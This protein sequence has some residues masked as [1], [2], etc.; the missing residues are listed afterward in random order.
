MR[1]ILGFGE[2]LD[3]GTCLYRPVRLC[4]FW[5]FVVGSGVRTGGVI[6]SATDAGEA[7]ALEKPVKLW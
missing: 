6:S 7:L 3:D 4:V 1:I 2:E 5:V